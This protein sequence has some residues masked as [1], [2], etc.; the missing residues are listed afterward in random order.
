MNKIISLI[1]KLMAP[2]KYA[3][4]Q[5]LEPEDGWRSYKVKKRY[6]RHLWNPLLWYHWIRHW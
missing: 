5:E 6:E 1:K 4:L 2:V 3:T